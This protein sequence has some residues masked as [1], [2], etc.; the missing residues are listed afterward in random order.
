MSHVWHFPKLIIK[1]AGYKNPGSG[2]N[3]P[4]KK[5]EKNSIKFEIIADFG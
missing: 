1:K 5:H 4:K 2:A 3:S